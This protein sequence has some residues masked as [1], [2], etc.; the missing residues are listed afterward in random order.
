[1]KKPTQSKALVAA[2]LLLA[3]TANAT[4]YKKA[5]NPAHLA[6]TL[7]YGYSQATVVSPGAHTVYV[8]G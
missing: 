5:L 2:M 7:G 6:S 3:S 4:E 1:M 8:S